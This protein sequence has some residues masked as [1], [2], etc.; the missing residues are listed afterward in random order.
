[1]AAQ[2]MNTAQGVESLPLA[3][4]EL[5]N[6]DG[7]QACSLSQQQAADYAP[8][9]VAGTPTQQYF[10]DT[11]HRLVSLYGTATAAARVPGPLGAGQVVLGSVAVKR[12]ETYAAGVKSDG[13]AL[14]VTQLAAEAELGQPV[15]KSTAHGKNGL[16]APSW[17]GY[18][19]LWVADRNPA[20][21][22]LLML[23]DGAGTP[24]E[25]SVPDLGNGRIESLRVAADGVRIAMLVT[26]NGSTTL[27]VGRIER[28][29]TA[30]H[31]ELTVT[32]LRQVTPYLEDVK[33]ASWAGVSRLVVV[34]QESGGVQQIQYV[35]VDGSTS[36][37]T[38]LPGIS[39][40]TSVAASEN[41]D[42]PLLAS[43]GDVIFR[44]PADAN[45]KEVT[46]KGSSPV[47]PG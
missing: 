10:I 14:Y 1:M 17:D 11:D 20:A 7:T 37:D 28:G 8:D 6:P 32:A 5:Q 4:V 31:P 27:R 30:G 26:A 34:G 42:K 46:P 35:G 43:L 12:D 25:V 44:L 24:V 39:G 33:A 18:G 22:R 9:K 15:L 16:S 13:S 29:G 21:P 38:T 41:Q 3:A 19:D 47:Y 45:W 2:L 40:V 23:K 36:D